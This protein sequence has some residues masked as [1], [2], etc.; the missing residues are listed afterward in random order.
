MA[1]LPVSDA[2]DRLLKISAPLARLEMVDLHDAMGRVL[3]S[4]IAALVTHPAFD[5]SAMDGYAGHHEDFAEVGTELVVIGEIG[6]RPRF[7]RRCRPGRGRSY[8]HWRT[9][10]CRRR[11]RSHSGRRGKTAGWPYP[12][13]LRSGKGPPYPPQGAGFQHWRRG[14]A[15]RAGAGCRAF[16]GRRRHEPSAAA[17]SG[18]AEGG[19]PGN[20]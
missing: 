12:D 17:G 7:W 15:R 11:C 20:R 6:G 3:A 5:N 19:D 9:C 16:D 13:H 14:F 10:S 4:D 8:L 18:T 1:L 2:L